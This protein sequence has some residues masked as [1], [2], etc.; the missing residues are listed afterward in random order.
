M[1]F[2]KLRR[3]EN[4]A[5]AVVVALALTV[6]CG[7]VALTVDFGM[8]ASTKQ[9]M[10]N[11]ADAAALAAAADIESGF[12][13]V[14]STAKEYA[15]I[16]GYDDDA[17]GITVE[18][19]LLTA[20]T[21]KVTIREEVQ[22]GFSTVLIGDSTRPVSASATAELTHIFGTS[23]YALFAGQ[24]IE[25]SGTG[26]EITGNNITINGN[27]HS[28][29]DIDMPNAVLGAGYQA[30]AV[31]DVSP[32]H[33]GWSSGHLALDMPSIDLFENAIRNEQNY[34]KIEGDITLKK[35][36]YSFQ[37]L[38]NDAVT[39]YKQRTGDTS[40]AGLARDGLCI[41]VTGSITENGKDTSTYTAPFP[42]ILIVDGDMTLNG[43][44]LSSSGDTP[45]YLMSKHGNITVNGGGGVFS[46]IVFAPEG[47]I[48]MHGN[49]A[50]FVGSLIAQ[51]IRKTGGKITITFDDLGAVAMPKNKVHLVE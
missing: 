4:G 31:R 47:D 20:Y 34:I 32:E 7:F 41:H 23:E 43:T 33:N 37:T 44:E 1:G 51:N 10:Q 15:R 19:D 18:V 40:L 36:H 48:E 3:N 35:N 46:G 14:E 13:V 6:L 30:T 2:R 12:G 8:M 11:A 22:M 28:N 50:E 25:E 49:D 5:A 24:K 29:S 38:V 45:F 21:V 42:I 16:N 27:M 39:I 26:I 9:D 17:P